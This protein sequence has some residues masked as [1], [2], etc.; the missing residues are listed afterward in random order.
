[1]GVFQESLE[2]LK[3]AQNKL[4]ESSE[5]LKKITKNSLDSEILVPLSASMYVP[6][7]IIDADNIIIDVG[8]GYYIKKVLSF[9]THAFLYFIFND[10]LNLFNVVHSHLLNVT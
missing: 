6:G 4:T 3:L 1:M 2:T 9:F 8:T 10:I 7:Q 5:S